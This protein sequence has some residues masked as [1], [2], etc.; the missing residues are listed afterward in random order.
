MTSIYMFSP[1]GLDL[2][3]L[4]REFWGFPDTK[5]NRCV[6]EIFNSEGTWAK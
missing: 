5:L 2:K 1:S 3:A 4:N 6:T